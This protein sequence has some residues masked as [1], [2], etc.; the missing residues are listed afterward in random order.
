MTRTEGTEGFPDRGLEWASRRTRVFSSKKTGARTITALEP[1][2]R[3]EKQITKQ[4]ERIAAL[5]ALP[6]EHGV[7]EREEAIAF[8]HGMLV[9]GHD[10][11]PRGEGAHEHHECGAR[12]VEIR[13][14]RIHDVERAPR[15]E[16]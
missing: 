6:D 7:S 12:D 2:G 9:G 11:I 16:V 3:P 4:G 13:D 10:V 5:E 15:E 1:L 8:A 14:E